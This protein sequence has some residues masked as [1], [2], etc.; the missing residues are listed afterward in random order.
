M[1]RKTKRPIFPDSYQGKNAEEYNHSYWMERNQKKTALLCLQ[2]LY[3]QHLDNIKD[4][5]EL[6]D[7]TYTI[8]DLGS[9]TG[10]SSEIL[11][12]NGFRVI[13]VEIL[14]DMIYRAKQKKTDYNDQGTSGRFRVEFIFNA[15]RL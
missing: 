2:Y 9:G 13:G 3:D 11:A 4:H 1:S 6:S 12:E 10:F 7:I 8:L 15:G 5:D 14:K